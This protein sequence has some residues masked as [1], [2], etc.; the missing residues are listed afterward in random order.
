MT[1]TKAALMWWR[2]CWGSLIRVGLRENCL[3]LDILSHEAVNWVE[4]E[5]AFTLLRGLRL[6]LRKPKL[7]GPG[8]W[9]QQIRK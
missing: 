3:P 7:K 9:K 4:M 2:E 8:L 5:S 1:L 6:V